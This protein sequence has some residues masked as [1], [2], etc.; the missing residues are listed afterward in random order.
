MADLTP[1]DVGKFQAKKGPFPCAGCGQTQ[2]NGADA[3]FIKGEKGYYCSEACLKDHATRQ[4]IAF[5]LGSLK[6]AAERS[7]AAAKYPAP[8]KVPEVVKLRCASCGE[9][10]DSTEL[11]GCHVGD[12]FVNI[13]KRCSWLIK[14]HWGLK[15]L[16]VWRP[17]PKAVVE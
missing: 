2:A 8:V 4:G 14:A 9:M 17:T 15:K 12:D 3:Y 11:V 5:S 10:V 6:K 7:D 1:G 16:R 13:C